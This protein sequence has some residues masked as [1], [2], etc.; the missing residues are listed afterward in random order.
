MTSA[1]ALVLNRPRELEPR[2]FEL[3]T[4]GADD[5]VLRIEACGLCGTD[6]EEYTGHL[7]APYGFIPG[8]EVVGVIDDRENLGA[9]KAL[10]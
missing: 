1:T 3:P 7:P 10:I 2:S 8:H 5:G 9:Q 4:V 6:H